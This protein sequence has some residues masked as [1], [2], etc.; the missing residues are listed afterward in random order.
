MAWCNVAWSC[1]HLEL[2]V[3]E[4]KILSEK[5]HSSV[6]LFRNQS[7]QRKSNSWS[8]NGFLSSAGERRAMIISPLTVNCSNKSCLIIVP[9]WLIVGWLCVT[10]T[11][12]V[13]P[14]VTNKTIQV[15]SGGTAFCGM[16]V[17]LLV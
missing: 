4:H 16:I 9:P 15:N 10:I 1:I 14:P 12:N 11:T 6:R 2:N 13:F 8:P 5:Q 17:A 7:E 3:L